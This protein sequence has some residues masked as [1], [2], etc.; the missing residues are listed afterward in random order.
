MK[1]NISF[2][3]GILLIFLFIC[4]NVH[5]IIPVT[6]YY[7]DNMIIAVEGQGYQ[8]N[9]DLK[10]SNVSSFNIK[11]MTLN[12]QFQFTHNTFAEHILN[13]ANSIS[14]FTYCTIY[15]RD[16][17]TYSPQKDLILTND[18]DGFYITFTCFDPNLS[19]DY[20]E[21]Y[22]NCCNFL[23]KEEIDH[24]TLSNEHDSFTIKY[25]QKDYK[26]NEHFNTLFSYT[27]EH[28]NQIISQQKEQ[29]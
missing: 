9:K 14:E 6:T 7:V 24:I 10:V 28:W 18:E 8:I 12:I 29:Q 21:G 27:E 11:E 1:R 15:T 22:E 5:A 16:G 19:S 26:S 20:E 4:P 23:Y 25:S 17:Q 3:S 13:M 2:L